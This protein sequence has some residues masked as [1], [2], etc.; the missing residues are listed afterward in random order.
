M[1]GFRHKNQNLWNQ[2]A[3]GGT[4][5]KMVSNVYWRL[6]YL[7]K[8]RM[9]IFSLSLLNLLWNIISN[10]Q[11]VVLGTYNKSLLALCMFKQLQRH[12][13]DKVYSSPLH[14]MTSK[15][16]WAVY[17]MSEPID[18]QVY[19]CP[20]CICWNKQITRISYIIHNWKGRQSKAKLTQW[21]YA[22]NNLKVSFCPY[23]RY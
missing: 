23:L 15:I 20:Q 2:G 6:I 3:E 13:C 16:V 21:C 4:D 7:G 18:S 12:L 19:Y 5:R 14:L 17:F 9:I 10:M 1:N 22:P 8:K 11:I